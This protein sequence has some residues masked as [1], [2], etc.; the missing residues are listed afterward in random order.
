MNYCFTHKLKEFDVTIQSTD[1]MMISAGV[2]GGVSGAVR[3][4]A[5]CQWHYWT[6]VSRSDRL[7]YFYTQTENIKHF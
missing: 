7:L 4:T 3:G 1:H 5:G 2:G 6:A